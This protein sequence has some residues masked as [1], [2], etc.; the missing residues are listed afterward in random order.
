[1]HWPTLRRICPPIGLLALIAATAIPV[2]AADDELPG[3]LVYLRRID[4]TI[5]QDIRYAT[6]ENFTGMKVPG[7]EAAECILLRPVAE[8][9]KRVQSALAVSGLSLKVYDCYRPLRAVRAFVKWVERPAIEGDRPYHH[10]RTPRGRLIA[11]GYISAASTHAR[12][13]TVDLTIVSQTTPAA[14]R[15][16]Q[17]GRPATGDCA[18]PARERR[19][20]TSVDM[21]TSFDCFDSRS[22]LSSRFTG[23]I[24]RKWRQRLSEAMTRGGFAGYDRE[25][26]HFTYDLSDRPVWDIPVTRTEP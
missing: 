15:A 3:D 19:P 26:W 11:L 9:L 21:G 10:P 2:M 22:A 13:D 4:R 14:S 20:D 7:Y 1:M 12:G 23:P 17:T 18:S 8:A 16:E 6:S 25:W 5:L 24:Q